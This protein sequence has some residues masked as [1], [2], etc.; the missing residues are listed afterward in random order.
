MPDDG[1]HEGRIGF[2]L[3]SQC[4]H[5]IVDGA[6]AGISF[7]APHTFQKLFPADWLTL[8][9]NEKLEH[10]DF[11]FS[12]LVNLI[13][14]FELQWFWG[15]LLLIPVVLLVRVFSVGIPIRLIG[16]KQNVAPHLVKILVWG[17][18]RGGISVALALSLPEG[19]ARD[20][21]LFL[22]YIVLIFD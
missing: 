6:G 22:T 15:G 4:Q 14:P 21:V 2:E 19:D 3:F 9:F 18:L 5:K 7:I 16:L 10:T 13:I 8:G 17:G 1:L 11:L 12:Q 20:L